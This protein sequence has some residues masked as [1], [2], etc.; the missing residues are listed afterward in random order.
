MGV[1]RVAVHK[2]N[3]QTYVTN[4]QILSNQAK[5]MKEMRKINNGGTTPPCRAYDP[6]TPPSEN[7]IPLEEWNADIFPWAD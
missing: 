3:H 1:V 5:M 6:V 2:E 7:T 4:K